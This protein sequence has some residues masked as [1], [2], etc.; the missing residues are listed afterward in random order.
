MASWEY[1]QLRQEGADDWQVTY[2]SPD[3]VQDV[4]GRR[5]VSPAMLNRVAWARSLSEVLRNIDLV[6]S[7]PALC[8]LAAAVV[9]IGGGSLVHPGLAAA[10][11]AGQ[12]LFLADKESS[13]CAPMSQRQ[14]RAR[15]APG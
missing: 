13:E 5:Q 4:G 2:F 9:A 7:I 1:C 15:T 12:A 3:L 8:F 6:L 14:C 10:H 11:G